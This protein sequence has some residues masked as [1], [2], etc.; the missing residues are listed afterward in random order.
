MLPTWSNNND[1]NF[2]GRFKKK[3]K[4][5]YLPRTTLFFFLNGKPS[6]RT[7][8]ECQIEAILI[9]YNVSV[10]RC[11]TCYVYGLNMLL[12]VEVNSNS[13]PA[14]A[15][16]NIYLIYFSKKLNFS[17]NLISGRMIVPYINRIKTDGIKILFLE[18]HWKV[19]QLCNIC[20]F[21]LG[22]KYLIYIG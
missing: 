10:Y 7:N 4:K 16:C 8:K 17:F 20:V 2:W 22:T 9:I 19:I 21:L 1:H 15:F 3:I 5:N 11:L 13:K 18:N 14:Q 12:T 6:R